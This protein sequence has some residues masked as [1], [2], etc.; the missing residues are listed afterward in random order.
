MYRLWGV[1][2]LGNFGALASATY[3][4]AMTVKCRQ[5]QKTES[6]H[7]KIELNFMTV[8]CS[9]SMYAKFILK[10]MA[11]QQLHSIWS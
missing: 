3:L 4:Q 7:V 1:S 9:C 11:S 10:S 2:L 6:L 8:Y 5:L